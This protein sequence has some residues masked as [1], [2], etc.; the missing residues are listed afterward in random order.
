MDASPNTPG[1][2]DGA[3]RYATTHPTPEVLTTNH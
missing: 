2:E 3:L 1:I